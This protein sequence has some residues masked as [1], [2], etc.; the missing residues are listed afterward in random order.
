[1]LLCTKNRE[2]PVGTGPALI[3]PLVTQ[4]LRPHFHCIPQ[5]AVL[6]FTPIEKAAP[7]LATSVELTTR[8]RRRINETVVRLGN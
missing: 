6:V 4:A 7:Q 1:M 8:E 3:P 5:E 2:G